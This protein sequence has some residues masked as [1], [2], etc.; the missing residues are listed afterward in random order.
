VAS[1]IITPI[2]S[3]NGQKAIQPWCYFFALEN[4]L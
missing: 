4:I 1:L 2:W 3:S